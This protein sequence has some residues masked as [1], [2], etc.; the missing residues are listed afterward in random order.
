MLYSKE[1]VTELG[2]QAVRMELD[3]VAVTPTY[4]LPQS[5]LGSLLV[6]AAEVA[7]DPDQLGTAVRVARGWLGL[8]CPADDMA[9]FRELVAAKP[10]APASCI[11]CFI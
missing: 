3:R 10:F 7:A 1:E 4:S 5:Y 11:G 6:R 8:Q 2:F 9:R